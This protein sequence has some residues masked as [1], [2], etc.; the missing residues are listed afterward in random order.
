[1]ILPTGRGWNYDGY[2][3]LAVLLALPR[4][5]KVPKAKAM[6]LENHDRATPK[7]RFGRW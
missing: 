1:V 4:D 5:R 6:V 2:E 7:S 3:I